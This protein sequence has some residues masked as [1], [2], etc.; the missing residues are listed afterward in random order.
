MQNPDPNDNFLVSLKRAARLCLAFIWIYLGLVPKLLVQVPL[1]QDVVRRTGLY[2]S[3]PAL[4]IR[5]IGIFEI[6]LGVWL[7]TGFRERLACAVT[8]M[9]II[10]LM[11][12]A[13]IQEPMLLA[14]P[15]GGMIKNLGLFVLAWIVW[16]IS[17]LERY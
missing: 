12:F 14:G 7:I 16:R 11:V 3:S 2:V 5:L 15:F 4:T 17:S 9:L 1:E 6:A 13:L 10:V 8:S